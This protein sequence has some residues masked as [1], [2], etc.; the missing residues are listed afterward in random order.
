VLTIFTT[1]LTIFTT[2]LTIFTTVLTIFTTVPTIFTTVLLVQR[3]H[4]LVVPS[5]RLRRRPSLQEQASVGRADR[6]VR[7]ATTGRLLAALSSADAQDRRRLPSPPCEASTR[8][9]AP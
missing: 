7:L 2:V 9:A 8:T 6:A 4:P 5:D 3:P 1:V